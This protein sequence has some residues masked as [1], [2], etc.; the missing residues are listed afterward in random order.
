MTSD[1]WP[2]LWTSTAEIA[3]NTW[4]SMSSVLRGP[5]LYAAKKL[6]P[7]D[8]KARQKYALGDVN[9]SL[10]HTA[11]GRVITIYHDCSSP[12][13]YSRIHLVQGTRGILR[14]Y[15]DRVYVVRKEPERPMREPGQILGI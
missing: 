13:P 9:V 15:P 5:N 7:D 3:S 14:K 11:M 8:C 6:G 2:S 12:R 1:R 4:F 10:I